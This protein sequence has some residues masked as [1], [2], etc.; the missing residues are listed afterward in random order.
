MKM[1]QFVKLA[2]IFLFQLKHPV[3][4]RAGLDRGTGNGQAL[5]CKLG[6]QCKLVLTLK[7]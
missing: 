7:K 3:L 5:Q 1:R 2:K 4:E 6:L